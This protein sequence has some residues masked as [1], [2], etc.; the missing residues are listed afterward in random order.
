MS[1]IGNLVKKL[2]VGGML[3]ASVGLA[4]ACS[5]DSDAVRAATRA[6][7]SE[8]TVVDSDYILNL[9]CEKGEM[10]YR[11]KGKNPQGQQTDATVCCGYLTPFKGCTIRY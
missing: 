5:S 4:G 7:W 10:A 6:G 8:V 9:T 1:N 3:I 2:L 11:I